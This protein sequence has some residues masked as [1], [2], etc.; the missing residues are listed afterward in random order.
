MAQALQLKKNNSI[1]CR[2]M[3]ANRK[4]K[5][6]Q[7]G[8]SRWCLWVCVF[9]VSCSFVRVLVGMRG[10]GP[11][12]CCFRFNEKPVPKDRVVGYMKTSQRCSNPAVLWVH[13]LRE[14][15][16]QH[17]CIP[18]WMRWTWPSCLCVCSGWRQ[19]QVVSCVPDLQPL[20]WRSSSAT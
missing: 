9:V 12:R 15:H 13:N 8:T 11:K 18:S 7:K 1:R 4:L 17:H 10:P 14:I 16:D 3:Q 5:R 2:L 6:E 20:G 19:W